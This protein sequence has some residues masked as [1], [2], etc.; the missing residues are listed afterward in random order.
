MLNRFIVGAIL[1]VL[2]VISACTDNYSIPAWVSEPQN[3]AGFYQVIVS[4]PKYD[5]RYKEQAFEQALKS[6][7]MQINVNVDASVS[8]KETEAF[9]LSYTDFSSSIQTSSRTQ[10]KNVELVKSSENKL[11]YYAHYRLNKQD[12]QQER[13]RQT[14]LSKNLA[15]DLLGKYDKALAGKRTNFIQT[16]S[17][18]IKALDELSDFVDMDLNAIYEGQNIN[19]YTENMQRLASLASNLKLELE[20]NEI[21]ARLGRKIDLQS[22]VS[23]KYDSK[24]DLIGVPLNASFSRGAGLLTTELVTNP[25]A[26]ALLEINSISSEEKHQSVAIEVNKTKLIELSSHPLVKK[27]LASLHFASTNLTLNVSRPKVFVDY[28]FNKQASPNQ[29][30]I[31]DRLRELKI[32]VV[33]DASIADYILKVELLSKQGSYIEYL[34]QYS[35]FC[36]AF[37]SLIDAQTKDVLASENLREVKST[38]L[39]KEQAEL[40]SEPICIK[41]LNQDQLYRLI[42]NY[43]FF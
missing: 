37:I 6:I 29:R 9:G 17:F 30:L 36:D 22:T 19:L 42:S 21:D 33:N 13:L 20:P 25:R 28:S 35:G 10:L 41:T 34:N 26:E 8:S 3:D 38:G 14:Q 1:M 27:M 7:S 15:L 2:I 31:E 24:L 32:E 5:N 18:I 11:A 12:Y 43:L 23:C 40:A 16:S 39:N 4:V